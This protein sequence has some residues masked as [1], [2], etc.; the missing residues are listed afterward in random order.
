MTDI[1][2]RLG[3]G[4]TKGFRTKHGFYNAGIN[5]SSD[6]ND[7]ECPPQTPF[8]QTP[9]GSNIHH[10]RGLDEIEKCSCCGNEIQ[11]PEVD[12]MLQ[13]IDQ[14]VGGFVD[15]DLEDEDLS[16]LTEQDLQILEEDQ[17]RH[18]V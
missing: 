4:R 17:S 16:N 12:K 11:S 5:G 18:W 1:N 7:S 6:L 14:E 9:G 8:V 3:I 13:E 15:G 2:S 10:D